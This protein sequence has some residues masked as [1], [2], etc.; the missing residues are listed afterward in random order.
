MKLYL[1][2]KNSTIL[3]LMEKRIC[4]QI[5][6]ALEMLEM[7]FVPMSLIAHRSKIV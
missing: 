5:T 6:V 3:L 1:K 4:I 2:V 7:V